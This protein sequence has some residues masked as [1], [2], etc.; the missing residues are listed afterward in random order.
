MACLY[1]KLCYDADINGSIKPI[2]LNCVE[3]LTDYSV[4]GP[5]NIIKNVN[6]QNKITCFLCCQSHYFYINVNLCDEHEKCFKY[7]YEKG[8]DTDDC[9]S[10]YEYDESYEE[11]FQKIKNYLSNMKDY[12]YK[13]FYQKEMKYDSLLPRHIIVYHQNRQICKFIYYNC[14]LM[15]CLN[16]KW[17][18]TYYGHS[19]FRNLYCHHYTILTINEMFNLCHFNI[20]YQPF[21]QL[22]YNDLSKAIQEQ[23][24]DPLITYQRNHYLC[25]YCDDHVY[26]FQLFHNG[27]E[28]LKIIS[29][30]STITVLNQNQIY[31]NNKCCHI[32]QFVGEFIPINHR[33]F[34]DIYKLFIH[35]N[36]K[37]WSDITKTN[38]K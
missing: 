9:D 14:I 31:T 22:I 24:N 12:S 19:E 4:Y 16:D 21:D 32:N 8:Y 6:Y 27:V 17:Y 3:T 18:T 26:S 1:H 33:Q 29:T 11:Q 36:K 38:I 10:G 35:Y 28:T 15:L 34:I 23:L 5:I 37:S 25:D 20:Q 30:D 7:K 13:V 2:C